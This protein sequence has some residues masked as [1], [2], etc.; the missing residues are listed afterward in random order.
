MTL[1]NVSAFNK[2]LNKPKVIKLD[3]ECSIFVK[4]LKNAEFAAMQE[5]CK[6][7]QSSDDSSF[8]IA[9]VIDIMTTLIVDEQ[10]NLIYNDDSK[11]EELKAN[12]TLDFIRMF[13]EK[14]WASYG[15]TEKELA[16]AEAQFRK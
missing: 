2:Y 15:F 8:D 10:G 3:D 6:A 7:L 5:K 16:S 9:P 11:K 14:V 12:I 13:F 1:S 4:Q